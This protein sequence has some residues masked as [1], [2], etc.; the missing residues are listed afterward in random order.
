MSG[1]R[2]AEAI[3]KR[4]CSGPTVLT[5]MEAVRYT[6]RIMRI[7]ALLAALCVPVLA[8]AD[9]SVQVPNVD[10]SGMTEGDKASL[11]KLCQ[12]YSSACGKAHSLEQSLRTD[13]KCKRSVF[14][15]RYMVRLFKLGLLPSEV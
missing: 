10:L 9:A 13:P 4:I 8:A 3:V 1:R 15:A 7:F 11:L 14:A 2:R 12:K 6:R 5:L